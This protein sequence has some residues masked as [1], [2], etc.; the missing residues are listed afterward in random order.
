MGNKTTTIIQINSGLGNQMF[1]YAFGLAI[2]KHYKKKV[3]YDILSDFN[4]PNYRKFELHP[5]NINFN[6]ANILLLMRFKPLNNFYIQLNEYGLFNSILIRYIRKY[7]SNFTYSIIKKIYHPQILTEENL[8]QSHFDFLDLSIITKKNTYLLGYFQNESFLKSIENELRESFKL[9]VDYLTKTPIAFKISNT[10]AISIHIRRGDYLEHSI[11]SILSIDYYYKAV[12]LIKSK[13]KSPKFFVFSDDITWAKLNLSD[14][15]SNIV[16][17]DEKFSD[18]S[19][20]DLLLM[21][22]CK[23]N[24]IANSTYSWWGAWLN[25]NPNKLIIAPSTWYNDTAKNNDTIEKL[26]PK[27]WIII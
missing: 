21:S 15:H 18:N 4:T 3:Y 14:L 26:I 22:Y 20:D 7:F 9:K 27:K 12:E 19:C 10:N 16:F 5:F 13:I 25:Q 6:K 2:E 17:L 1:Q 8:I 11:F 24:I 23:H